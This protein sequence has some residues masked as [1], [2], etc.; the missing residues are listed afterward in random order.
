MARF[1]L[2]QSGK[3]Y[4][5]DTKWLQR[6]EEPEHGNGNDDDGKADKFPQQRANGPQTSEKNLKRRRRGLTR[7]SGSSLISETDKVR[8]W[9]IHLKPGERVGFH[10]HFNDGEMRAIENSNAGD[11]PWAMALVVGAVLEFDRDEDGVG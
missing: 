5:A 9:R 1:D 7:A 4:R 8:V 2:V 6:E 11:P 10:R 3:R